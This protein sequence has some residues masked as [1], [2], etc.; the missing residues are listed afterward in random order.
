[1]KKE[2]SSKY[3]LN[4]LSLNQINNATFCTNAFST[5]IKDFSFNLEFNMF[6]FENVTSVLTFMSSS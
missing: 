1:M 6:L 3:I 5:T 2:D 4:E